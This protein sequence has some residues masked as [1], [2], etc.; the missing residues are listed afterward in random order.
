MLNCKVYLCLIV[1][2]QVLVSKLSSVRWNLVLCFSPKPFTTVVMLGF[3]T[4]DYNYPKYPKKYSSIIIK[5]YTLS[6]VYNGHLITATFETID[7]LDNC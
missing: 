4:T 5:I 3:F 6:M 7:F 2:Y 1:K